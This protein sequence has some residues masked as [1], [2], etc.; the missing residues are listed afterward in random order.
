LKQIIAS[1]KLFFFLA[2]IILLLVVFFITLWVIQ[3]RSARDFRVL[4]AQADI[5]IE[6]RQFSTARDRLIT[7][8]QTQLNPRQTL[9]I[10]RR[11]YELLDLAGDTETLDRVT[12]VGLE[13]FPGN[14]DIR[15]LRINFLLEME[16]VLLASDL[17]HSLQAEQWLP[18]AIEAHLKARVP[19]EPRLATLSLP[20]IALPI[21]PEEYWDPNQFLQAWALTR[22]LRYLINASLLLSATGELSQAFNLLSPHR[23]RFTSQGNL[24]LYNLLMFDLFGFDQ[25]VS[26]F[27]A[28]S[29]FIERDPELYRYLAEMYL[30]Q[31]N[32]S[33]S[34]RALIPLIQDQRAQ[35][36]DFLNA[37]RYVRSTGDWDQAQNILFQG[38]ERFP[39][40]IE[41]QRAH[42]GILLNQGKDH[43]ARTFAQGYSNP[44][45]SH[46]EYQ[47]WNL[48]LESRVRGY[49]E[50]VPQLW[51]L[52]KVYPDYEPAQTILVWILAIT[53]DRLGLQEMIQTLSPHDSPWVLAYQGLVMLMEGN[54]QGALQLQSQI[55]LRKSFSIYG[56]LGAR[57]GLVT[58][59]SSDA[60][61]SFDLA[62]DRGLTYVEMPRDVREYLFSLAVWNQ[63]LSGNWDQAQRYFVM[64]STEF[65]RS[66]QISRLNWWM[67]RG[68]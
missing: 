48:L 61:R 4:L 2:L 46:P 42:I 15:G 19:L 8:N 16:Q 43:E 5:A 10:I 31:G 62:F 40:S 27:S 67:G 53:G 58:P 26:Q 9:R 7:L 30:D 51:E 57:L 47:L 6:D 34:S 39:R 59:L 28:L 14:Q 32:L 13:R 33:I 36:K 24:L 12:R 66:V 60:Q 54:S 65:P 49:S 22:D 56:S 21:P 68:R 44:N 64:L 52:V 45:P 35:E 11:A 55:P 38:L 3:F 23:S 17:S 41:L 18:Y 37:S 1:K 29:A 63:I 20:G 25:A 50:L